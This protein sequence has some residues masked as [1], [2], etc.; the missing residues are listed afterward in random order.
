MSAQQ[1]KINKTKSVDELCNNQ[2]F[3]KTNILWHLPSR[4]TTQQ[5]RM[6]HDNKTNEQCKSAMGDK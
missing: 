4:K 3:S 1:L 5:A 6:Q 2:L